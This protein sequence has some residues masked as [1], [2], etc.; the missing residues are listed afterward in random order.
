[1]QKFKNNKGGLGP[2]HQRSKST[3]RS[4][5]TQVETRNAFAFKR[6]CLGIEL[7][8]PASRGHSEGANL[9][10]TNTCLTFTPPPLAPKRGCRFQTIDCQRVFS[11]AGTRFKRGP[12]CRL[13]GP[14]TNDIGVFVAGQEAFQIILCGRSFGLLV[15][16]DM[17]RRS[18]D[19]K[20]VIISRLWRSLRNAKGVVRDMPSIWFR[21]YFVVTQ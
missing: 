18:V 12:I 11:S 16:I 7:L 21:A 6:S 15:S 5:S 17:G 20:W 3:L 10:N 2:Y 1:M 13:N 9:Y 14:V 19:C 4:P 8:L